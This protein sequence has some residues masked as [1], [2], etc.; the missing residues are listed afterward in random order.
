M[1][2]PEELDCVL[3]PSMTNGS[4]IILYTEF[5]YRVAH[6]KSESPKALRPLLHI[7][8]NCDTNN[9]KLSTIAKTVLLLAAASSTLSRNK[10]GCHKS[11]SPS[12][13]NTL[14]EGRQSFLLD[15]TK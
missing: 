5:S 7:S 2:D 6:F 3:K 4:N 9:I 12:A 10:S 13:S 11:M 1:Q 8:P 15:T 14:D